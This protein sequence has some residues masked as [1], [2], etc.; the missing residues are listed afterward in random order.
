MLKTYINT[1]Q[2][3]L[4][5]RQACKLKY[6]DVYTVNFYTGI[7]VIAWFAVLKIMLL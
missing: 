7:S 5:I 3:V 2:S 6:G 4:N 1:E